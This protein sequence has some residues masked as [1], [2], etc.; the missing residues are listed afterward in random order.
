MNLTQHLERLSQKDPD[1]RRLALS[2]VFHME[3]LDFTLQE[4]PASLS[5]PRGICNYLLTPQ[6]SA[7]SLLFCAHYDA[8]PGSFGA[9]D[10]AA[11]VCILI[12][13]AK[14]LKKE[15]F[16]ARFAFF[17]QEENKQAGSRLYAASMDKSLVT[18]VVNLD[19]CGFGDTL[20][21]C[22]KTD[23]FCRKELLDRHRGQ[24]VSYLPASDDRS[25]RGL[26]IPVLSLAV[27]PR[28]DIQYL[29]ALA[30]YGEG[31]FGKPPE[32]QMILEQMEIT[33]TMHGGYRDALQ[34]IEP[35]AM[36]QMY[37]Y[38]FEAVHLAPRKKRFGLF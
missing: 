35:E 5:N 7:P 17:D 32:Y 3:G 16:P 34:W 18:G 2:E 21:V 29:K 30:A 27:V 14:E 1:S 11:A 8:V 38:L 10:N 23:P 13:L 22:G 28:W 6:S 26:R 19:L 37:Q 24:A 15:Q 25:F 12:Q 31:I 33:S 9:N 20:A 36:E 4:E